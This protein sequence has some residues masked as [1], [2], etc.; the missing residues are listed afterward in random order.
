MASHP[1]F[2]EKT[3]AAEVATIF[4]EEIK[5]KNIII[6]GVSPSS[7]GSATALAIASQGPSTLILASR[8]ESKLKEVVS[9]INEEYPSVLVTAVI[10]DLASADS[11]KSAASQIGSLVNYVDILINNAGVSLPARDLV[12]TPDGSVVD[13]QFFINHL[14][15]FFFTSLL[16]PQLLAVGS[17]SPKGVTRIINLSSHGH[18]LSPIRFSDYQFSNDV[19]DVPEDERPPPGL[20][21]QFLRSI[22]GYPGF[23]GYGQSKTANILYATELARRL[24]KNDTNVT[25]FSLHPGAIWTELSRSLDEEGR[26]TI[27]G[28][29]PNG[30]WKTLEQGAATTLVAAFDP[31]LAELDVGGTVCGFLSDCQLTDDLAMPWARDPKTAARLWDQSEKMMGIT[32]GL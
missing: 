9:K 22:D 23:M 31:K 7:I 1:E 8:T 3:T 13:L 20:P 28:T 18:R 10:L 16:L 15:P 4:S 19:Y 14:G 5:G 6:T 17:L 12:T 29:A 11:I 32:T 30:W 2:G 21:E 27:E 24:R 26:K 25:A